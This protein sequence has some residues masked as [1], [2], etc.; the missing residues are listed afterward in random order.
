MPGEEGPFVCAGHSAGAESC[1]WFAHERP[2]VE[3]VAMM[4]GYPDLIRAGATRPVSPVTNLRA[5][6]WHNREHSTS[7]SVLTWCVILPGSEAKQSDA[8]LAARCAH[9]L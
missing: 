2:D 6:H 9:P 5:R 7:F 3:G 1:L 8:L 4:D